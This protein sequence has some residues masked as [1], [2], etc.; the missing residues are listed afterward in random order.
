M[1]LGAAA[2]RWL[3]WKHRRSRHHRQIQSRLARCL[4]TQVQMQLRRQH[5]EPH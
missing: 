5:C 1:W 2:L 3:R 4:T